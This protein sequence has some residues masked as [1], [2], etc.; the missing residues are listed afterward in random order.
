MIFASVNLIL[1]FIIKICTGT[2]FF[3]HCL[4]KDEKGDKETGYLSLPA[5]LC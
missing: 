5:R 1:L 4:C 2:Y 3:C